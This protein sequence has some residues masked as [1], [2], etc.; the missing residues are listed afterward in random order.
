MLKTEL[1]K[2]LAVVGKAHLVDN[3]LME[4][5]DF[6]EKQAIMQL[7]GF[8]A[9]KP[10]DFYRDIF[11]VGSFERLGHQEDEKPNGIMLSINADK[12]SNKKRRGEHTIL[13]DGFEQLSV[14]LEH[15]FVI[16][17]P[18]SYFGRSRKASNAS[19]LYA[20]T[21]DIDYV[22]SNNL[23]HLLT[24]RFDLEPRYGTLPVPTYT[25][26]TGHGIHLYYVLEK[27]VPMYPD[28]QKELLRLKEFLVELVWDEYVS[29]DVSKKE[30]LGLTQGFRMVG[31]RSKVF[32][33][34]I[35]AYKTG[36]KCTLEWLESFDREGKLKLKIK[37]QTSM[38]LR[39]AKEKYPEWYE[40][41]VI[42]KQPVGLRDWRP[43]RDL[44]D[45]WKRKA[46]VGIKYG[47]RYFGVMA[48]A[49][50]A[51][52]CGIDYEEL[53]SDALE[54]QAMFETRGDDPFTVEDMYN[55]LEAYNESYRTF[56]RKDIAR[57]TAL[58][59]PPN[60][61]NYQSQRDHLEEAR[62]LRDIRQRRKGT[63]WWDNGNRDGRPVGSGTKKELILNYKEEH[64]KATQREIAKALGVS[65][66][67][68]NK[69]LKKS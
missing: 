1:L 28:N 54:L 61:R 63:N 30:C 31:S 49:I 18:I 33:K 51:A 8:S 20:L 48:L 53:E 7:H 66:T 42:L 44:Y 27:P 41:R 65:P 37:E 35:T 34:R 32:N 45:W 17:S 57:L 21:L 10:F 26:N 2:Q 22:N 24:E 12:N 55:A 69:W 25:V 16:T 60:K 46:E 43:K 67:T 13:T 52:K 39:E 15:P 5:Y 29:Y 19:L 36:E 50:Y 40:K 4:I 47:H 62:A 68:V 64:P 14:A 9:V 11:P 56:P 58:E 59:I 38:S 23:D 6:D 3:V